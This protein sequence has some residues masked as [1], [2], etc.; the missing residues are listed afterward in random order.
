[1]ERVAKLA[2]TYFVTL[3]T[4]KDLYCVRCYSTIANPVSSILVNIGHWLLECPYAIMV[5]LLDYVN[6][7]SNQVSFFLY[8]SQA[9]RLCKL[10]CFMPLNEDKMFI[11]RH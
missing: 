4:S 1:M 3:I 7:V 8:N 5:P 6:L 11:V 10:Q 2:S 9:A